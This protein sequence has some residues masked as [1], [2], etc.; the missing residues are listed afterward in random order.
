MG[1]V[2]SAAD[3][4][5]PNLSQA[6][7]L[8]R[9]SVRAVF[10]ALSAAGFEAR[11]VGGCVRNALLGMPARDVDIATDAQPDDVMAASAAHNLRAIETGIA[12]GT[13]TLVAHGE[14]IEV[15]TLRE[16]VETFGRHALVTFTADWAA[17]AGRRDFTMNA[18]YCDGEGCV[19]D[20]L[21]GIDDLLARRVRFIGD[22]RARIGEDFLRI[23]RFFRLFAEFGAGPPDRTALQAC[24]AERQGLTQL[25]GERVRGEM[26]RLLAAT[27][28]TAAIEAMLDFGLLPGLLATAPQPGRLD[29]LLAIEQQLALEPGSVLRLGALAVHVVEDAQRLSKRLRLSNQQA[30]C[31]KTFAVAAPQITPTLPAA[32]VRA[33]L[34]RLGVQDFRLRVLA[35]WLRSGEPAADDVWAALYRVPERWSAPVLPVSGGDLLELG[36]APG[37]EVGKLLRA[38]EDWWVNGDFSA[39]RDQLRARLRD[40]IAARRDGAK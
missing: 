15:T 35:S 4:E 14:A 32:G 12:H 28:V 11:A 39:D 29:H 31:L 2:M 18:L 10:T 37:P 9:A 6:E 7:W 34:Y 33:M 40:L 23:L 20:P 8:H 16:D 19:Y 13:V 27:R 1:C 21:G 22:A 25:S 17:D 38:L 30:V 3:R 5:L 36:V 24:L 26:L